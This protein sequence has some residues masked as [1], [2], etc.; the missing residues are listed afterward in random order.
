VVRGKI[1]GKEM[2]PG[3]DAVVADGDVEGLLTTLKQL[4]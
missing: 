4:L 1:V 2:P 3:V